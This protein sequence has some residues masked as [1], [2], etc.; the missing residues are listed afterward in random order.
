MS[1]GH[2]ASRADARDKS[3]SY[4][5]TVSGSPKESVAEDAEGWAIVSYKK[6]KNRSPEP[7]PHKSQKGFRFNENGIEEPR[8]YKCGV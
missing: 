8:C 5:Q 2:G 7:E 1:A 3:L 4:A 6:K